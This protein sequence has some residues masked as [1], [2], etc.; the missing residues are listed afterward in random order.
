MMITNLFYDITYVLGET[1]KEN[2]EENPFEVMKN[3]YFIT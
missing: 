3:L 1:K 2:I